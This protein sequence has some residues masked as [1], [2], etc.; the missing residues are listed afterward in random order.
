MH[1]GLDKAPD[2]ILIGVIG[3][4]QGCHQHVNA[5]DASHRVRIAKV[6]TKLNNTLRALKFEF[7]PIPINCL[8]YLSLE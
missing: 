1:R 3:I 4:W 8:C 6:L 5:C 2:I 7:M